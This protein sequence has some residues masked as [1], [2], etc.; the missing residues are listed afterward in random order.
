MFD[1]LKSN[2]KAGLRFAVLLTLAL[3]LSSIPSYAIFYDFESPTLPSDILVFGTSASLNIGTTTLRSHNGNRSLGVGVNTY[4]NDWATA[5][6]VFANPMTAG[7]ISWWQYDAFG[8]Q[9]P[10]Y[11]HSVLL[12]TGIDPAN[13]YFNEIFGVDLFDRGWGGVRSN[14]VLYTP[15]KSSAPRD[16]STGIQRVAGSWSKYEFDFKN[17]NLDLYVNDVLAGSFSLYGN[18]IGGVYFSMHDYYG[19]PQQFQIDSLSIIDTTQVPV[20]EPSTFLL[21]GAGLGGFA[22]WRRKKRQ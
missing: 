21:F 17:N 2:I 10:Y 6:L 1:Y 15:F 19:G 18:D 5:Y 7:K 8:N 11:T 12:G 3:H 22:I 4:G 16:Y 13:V 9:S 14:D 20:P